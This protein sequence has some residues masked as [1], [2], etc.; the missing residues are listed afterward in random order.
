MSLGS[1]IKYLREKRNIT[2]QELGDMIG[3]S[4]QAIKQYEMDIAR[5]QPIPL[6]KLA[7]ALETTA[8]DLVLR[9]EWDS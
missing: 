5:P 4:K 2:M 9:T 1:N 7:Q 6:V 3:V 8:E